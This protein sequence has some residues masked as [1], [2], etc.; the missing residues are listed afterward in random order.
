M[1]VVAVTGASGFIGRNFVNLLCSRRVDAIRVLTH[2][3]TGEL[4]LQCSNLST[5]QGDLLKSDS[6]G[7]LL[8]PGCTVVNLAYIRTDNYRD[9]VRAAKNIATACV[10]ANVKRLV[11]CSSVSVFG[12]SLVDLVDE[13]TVCKPKTKYGVTK[14]AWE[15]ALRE[16]SANTFELV[17]LRPTI[18]FGSGGSALKGLV[19]SCS[20]RRNIKAIAKSFLLGHRQMNLVHVDNV[21]AAIAFLVDTEEQ[22]DGETFII[23]D[24]ENPSNNYRDVERYLMTKLNCPNYESPRI[25]ASPMV[26]S[27]VLRILRRD[28]V[29][30]MRVY[31][32]QKLAA[33][34]FRKPRTLEEGLASFVEWYKEVHRVRGGA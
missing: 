11:H 24:C 31:G 4:G 12:D 13:G 10:N 8:E 23:S 2:E 14:L 16:K 1:R 26:L 17:I 6:L 32:C 18:V 5:V 28:S 21:T 7:A 30:S 33:M 29:N 20:S 15:N 27:Y 25:S 19:K 34:G 9:N 3:T 22:I